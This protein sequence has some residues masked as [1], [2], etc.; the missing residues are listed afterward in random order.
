MKWVHYSDSDKPIVVKN[1]KQPTE[2]GLY[3]KP[4]GLWITPEH[5]ED[6]WKN[7]CEAE[8]F[9]LEGLKYVHD[10]VLSDKA[11][12]LSI[13]TH[14][15][16]IAF[17]QKYGIKGPFIFQQHTMIDWVKVA[18]EYDG[19]LIYPYIQEARFDITWYYPWDCSSGCIWSK[20]AVSSITPRIMEEANG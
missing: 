20:K 18:L 4:S 6:N 7:W 19:I 17:D 10:V 15:E 14:A 3:L 5:D 13:G 2:I 16:L 11:K 12:L 8:D 9:R 1:K